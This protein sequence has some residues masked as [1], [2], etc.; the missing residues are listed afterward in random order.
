VIISVGSLGGKRSYTALYEKKNAG[1]FFARSF[2]TPAEY[3]D[4]FN[5]NVQAGW[6]LVYLNAYTHVDGLRLTAIWQ[7]EAA[8]SL[9]ARHGM[10]SVQYQA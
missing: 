5:Q 1:G 10:S 3:Q 7:M 6:R 4:V 2:L 8:N 9:V